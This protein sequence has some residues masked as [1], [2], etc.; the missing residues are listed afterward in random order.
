MTFSTT[1]LLNVIESSSEVISTK[2]DKVPCGLLKGS[3]R[4]IHLTVMG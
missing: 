2:V 1:A 4:E 3:S